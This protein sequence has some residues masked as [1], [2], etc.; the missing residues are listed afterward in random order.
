MDT[1]VEED[2]AMNF[3]VIADKK[4]RLGESAESD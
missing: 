3:I 1:E 4:F 2:G